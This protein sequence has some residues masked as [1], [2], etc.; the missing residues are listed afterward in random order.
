MAFVV[1]SKNATKKVVRAECRRF[2]STGLGLRAWASYGIGSIYSLVFHAI[3]WEVQRLAH[4][5][6]KVSKLLNLRFFIFTDNSS[7]RPRY[8]FYQYA[9]RA[10]VAMI[11][12]CTART[13]SF[14][15]VLA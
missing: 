10:V 11:G 9:V 4:G 2:A 5:F 14:W 6:K 1:Y 15:E 12:A 3:P 8:A 13:H 7:P